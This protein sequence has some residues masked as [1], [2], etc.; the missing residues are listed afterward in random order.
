M[1]GTSN[2]PQLAARSLLFPFD[3]LLHVYRRSR[4]FARD[5][6]QSGAGRLLFTQGRERLTEAE[7]GLRRFGGSLELRR[8]GEKGFGGFAIALA[9]K[10]SLAQPVMGVGGEAIAGVFF[11]ESP[12]AFF[13]QGIILAQHVTV[14][15]VVLVP[16]RCARRE[17]RAR[18]GCSVAAR[19]RR[20]WH[21]GNLRGGD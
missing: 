5:L 14:G 8:H 21:A 2:P 12:E 13:T 19:R 6:A 15:E 20:R 11:Q 7:Q 9:L 4:V 10:L 1:E 16:R 3:A 17:R 18:G